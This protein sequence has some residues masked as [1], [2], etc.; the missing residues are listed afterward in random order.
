MPVARAYSRRIW[1]FNGS[2][3]LGFEAPPPI[4]LQRGFSKRRKSPDTL[5]QHVAPGMGQ[6]KTDI[7]QQTER[8]RPVKAKATLARVNALSGSDHYNKSC[9]TT[10]VQRVFPKWE[11]ARLARDQG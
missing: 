3:L 8:V 10:R 6:R 5:D 9:Y 1:L 7:H 4:L 2:L 11:S